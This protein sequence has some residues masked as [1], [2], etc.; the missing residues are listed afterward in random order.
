MPVPS[1][2]WSQLAE[3]HERVPGEVARCTVPVNAGG[4]LGCC[5][6]VVVGV[7]PLGDDENAIVGERSG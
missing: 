6:F 3:A 4:A 1:R 7:S 5:G 2:T